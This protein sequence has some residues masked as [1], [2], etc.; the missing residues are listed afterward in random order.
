[1][2]ETGKRLL[3]EMHAIVRAGDA[4]Q[5]VPFQSGVDLFVNEEFEQAINAF[6]QAIDLS[7][8]FAFAHYYLA[9]SLRR[10]GIY[11]GALESLSRAIELNPVHAPSHAYMGDIFL[12]QGKLAEAED[13]FRRALDLQFD[14][15]TALSGLV[16]LAKTGNG[17]LDEIAGLLKDAYFR[18]SNNPILLMELFSFQPAGSEIS[19][20]IAALAAQNSHGRAL[21]FYRMA[22]REGPTNEALQ[23]KIDEALKH[24]E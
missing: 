12:R 10:V 9:R 2:D 16:K 14:N 19:L 15:A 3:R 8:D 4:D 1:M 21:F 17:N 24:L 13:S 20:R 18:G 23:E 5:Q 7:P 22:L 11:D 6:R